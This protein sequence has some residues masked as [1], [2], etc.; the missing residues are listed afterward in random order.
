MVLS[1][2]RVRIAS[3]LGRI[4]DFDRPTLINGFS[5]LVNVA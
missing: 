2:G 3:G 4:V 5:K 1:H